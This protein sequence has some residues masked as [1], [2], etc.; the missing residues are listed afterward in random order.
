MEMALQQAELTPDV[1]DYVNAH[2][3]S[4]PKGDEIEALVINRMVVVGVT[5]SVA[6]ATAAGGSNRSSKRQRD[7]HVSSTKGATGHLLGA[8]GAIEA[9]FTIQ[10]LV[11]RRIPPTLN[12]EHHGDDVHFR[13]VLAP[14]YVEDLSV[15]MSNSF[16]FG[17]TN[18]CLLFRK[19]LE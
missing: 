5:A 13:H 17:G 19:I 11:E 2:A 8:A 18:A 3:T 6:G 14:T 1:V 9:A 4:T 16:G 10:T 12:L 15:A 7:L